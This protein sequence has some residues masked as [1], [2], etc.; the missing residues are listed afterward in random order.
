M[1]TSEVGILSPESVATFFQ[2]QEDDLL[3]RF[4]VDSKAIRR[5]PGASLIRLLEL[6]RT[7]ITLVL[8][9]NLQ[10]SSFQNTLNCSVV[11]ALGSVV[12]PITEPERGCIEGSLRRSTD[13]KKEGNGRGGGEGGEGVN[14]SR[15][16]ISYNCVA[17]AVR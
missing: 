16:C 15:T 4:V 12:L 5:L 6:G 7:H 10:A 8:L 14:T 9:T 13:G 2:S 17:E 11:A 1:R 3:V